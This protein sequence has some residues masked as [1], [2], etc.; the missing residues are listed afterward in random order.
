MDAN[1][2][3]LTIMSSFTRTER[4]LSLFTTLRPGEGRVALQLC[5]QSF[6]IM[7]AYY[8]LKVIREPLIL[9]D[10]SSVLDGSA[11]IKAYSTALQAILLMLIV[12][13][14]ARLYQK[15]STR[16]AKHHLYRNTIM[17]F[18]LNLV[19]F[20]VAYQAGVAIGVAFYIWLGIFSVMVLALFW[21]FAADL[22]NLKSGQRLFPLIAA[23]AAFGALLG[24]GMAGWMDDALGHGG[25]M[26]VAALLLMMPWWL[27][28]ST[29]G[30]I[31]DGSRCFSQES[32]D[33]EPHAIL[34]GFKIVLQNRYLTLIACL[35][36][37]LNL[38]NTNGEYI[39][40]TFVTDMAADNSASSGRSADQ[41]IT[42][43]YSDYLFLTT[44]AGFLIQLFLV[45]RI[46]D[47]IGVANSLFVLPIIMIAGYSLLALVPVIM[48]ARAVMISE[49]SVNYSLETTAR[50]ALFLPVSREDKYVG[51]HTIDTFFFRLG[52]VFSGGFVYLA[53][54]V[55]GIGLV[56]FISI[57]IGLSLLLLAISMAI[58]KRHKITAA[59][60]LSNMPP[61]V[62]A[63]LEDLF[64]PA[65]APSQFQIDAKT[66]VDPDVGDALRY[67]AFANHSERLPPWIKFDGLNR[68]FNFSPP[69]AKDGQLTIR[70][71]AKDYDGLEAEV[72]FTVNYGVWGKGSAV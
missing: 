4:L 59:E 62:A 31:P 20:A 11:E 24:S 72:C 44:L 50:H 42:K 1:P 48:I 65:G 40:T 51:K 12:P 68:R 15:L 56:G 5:L 60:R 17:V 14:F 38:I 13:V 41:Y 52:D 19:A 64:I 26:W 53:S 47:R 33:T 49:N 18:V 35:V 21:A 23:A 37:V 61:V 67:S 63:P 28:L 7:F 39:L 70:V 8:Q 46:F 54:V 2:I 25:V 9:A 34:H 58:S 30:K 29:E 22:F 16:E 69:A 45:S 57:N 71:V 3:L 43:F 36:I 27:S 10:G 32:S 6:L 55:V 66:F